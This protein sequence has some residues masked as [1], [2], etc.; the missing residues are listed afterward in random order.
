MSSS[1]PFND[2]R[3]MSNEIPETVVFGDNPKGDGQGPHFMIG[4]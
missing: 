4:S 3:T 2:H 1:V